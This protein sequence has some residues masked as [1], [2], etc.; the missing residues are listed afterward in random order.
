MGQVAPDMGHEV[1][2]PSGQRIQEV[3]V[4]SETVPCHFARVSR[5]SRGK[6]RHSVLVPLTM[7]NVLS[8]ET[9]FIQEMKGVSLGER[10][11]S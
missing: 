10:D 9:V 7:G 6:P 8:K 11:K 4:D 5:T 3:R 1:Q 2:P